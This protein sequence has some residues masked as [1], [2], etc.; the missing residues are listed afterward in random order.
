VIRS[1][2]SIENWRNSIKSLLHPAG[3]T[4]F[5]EIN[6]DTALEEVLS[7]AVKPTE[8]SS[9]TIADILTADE[10][11]VYASNTLLD[12]TRTLTADSISLSI[13]L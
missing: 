4:A 12:G 13:N 2:I 10:P 11:G 9:I 6:N 3:L 1:K 7:L 8:E 5:S